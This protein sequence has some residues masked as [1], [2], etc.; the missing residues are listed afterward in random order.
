MLS[1]PLLTRGPP[2]TRRSHRTVF[3]SG[4]IRPHRIWTVPPL[5]YPEGLLLLVHHDPPPN[6]RPSSHSCLSADP[7]LPNLAASL[8]RAVRVD[9]LSKISS[10]PR[11]PW[12]LARN[13]CAKRARSG[14]RSGWRT[15]GRGGRSVGQMCGVRRHNGGSHGGTAHERA[16]ERRGN[17]CGRVGSQEVCVCNLVFNVPLYATQAGYD[18]SSAEGGG[19]LYTVFPR[20]SPSLKTRTPGPA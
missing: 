15:V 12:G 11:P 7:S 16:G 19:V 20:H 1:T 8:K 9:S 4:T 10:G 6:L 13:R 14:G 5:S 2:D 3:L 17:S 18:S